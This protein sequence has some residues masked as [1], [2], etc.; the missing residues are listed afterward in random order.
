MSVA[1]AAG[2]VPAVRGERLLASWWPL[3]ALTALAA[4]LRFA[5]LGSQS[6]WYDEAFTPVHVLHPGLG[7]TLHSVVHT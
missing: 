2:T 6:L 1:P 7:A 4:A 5:T 3:L